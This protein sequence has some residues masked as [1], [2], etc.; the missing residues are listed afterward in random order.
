MRNRRALCFAN[1]LAV[2]SEQST[3]Q[4]GD[5]N[6]AN[7]QGDDESRQQQGA[8]DD[9]GP[10]SQR[11]HC[12]DG[13]RAEQEQSGDDGQKNLETAGVH[14]ISETATRTTR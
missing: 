9:S 12:K 2:R 7:E 4:P 13:D 14:S 10:G 11:K 3:H 8:I 5:T 6:E 1:Q